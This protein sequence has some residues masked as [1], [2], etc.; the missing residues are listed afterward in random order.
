MNIAFIVIFP[1]L[2][3]VPIGFELNVGA[4]KLLIKCAAAYSAQAY[5]GN[6][7][8]FSW[9]K[10]QSNGICLCACCPIIISLPISL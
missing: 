8:R 1:I 5:R 10:Q 2:G 6:C 9:T 7:E 3:T 4:L